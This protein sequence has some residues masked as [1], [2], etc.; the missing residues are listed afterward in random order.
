MWHILLLLPVVKSNSDNWAGVDL[1]F[2]LPGVAGPMNTGTILAGTDTTCVITATTAVNFVSSTTYTITVT[3]GKQRVVHASKGSWTNNNYGSK[4]SFTWESP[5]DGGDV[6]F[7]A[8]CATGNYNSGNMYSATQRIVSAYVPPAKCL[9]MQPNVGTFC[10][11]NGN[12]GL[13]NAAST[14]DCS[15]NPCAIAADASVCCKPAPP[16][17]CSTITNS[18]AFC[19]NNGN[20]GINPVASCVGIPCT[21][22]D[23]PTCCKPAANAAKCSSITDTMTF[24]ANKGNNGLVNNPGS[25]SCA[26]PVCTLSADGSTCCKPAPPAKCSSISNPTTFCPNNGNNGLIDDAENTFCDTSTCVASRDGVICCKPALNAAKCNTIT[27]PTSFCINHGNDG[28]VANPESIN[29]A[30]STCN[31]NPDAAKCC[32][33]GSDDNGSGNGS[34]SN[35][36]NTG[37]APSA[38]APAPAPAPA[39]TGVVSGGGVSISLDNTMSAV[40]RHDKKDNNLLN[41][42]VKHKGLGWFGIGVSS[43]GTMSSSGAGSDL[44]LCEEGNV[45]K[46]YWSVSKNLPTDG[47]VMNGATCEL[48]DGTSTMMFSRTYAKQNVKQRSIDKAGNTHFI[49]AWHATSKKLVYHT[50]RGSLS[51]KNL[52]DEL[53]ASEASGGTVVPESTT[54]GD[55]ALDIP[56]SS[57]IISHVVSMSV[58]WGLLLP[59]GVLIARYNR[60]SSWWFNVHRGIQYL[61]WAVQIVGVVMAF[62][63]KSDAHFLGPPVAVFHMILGIVVVVIGTLQPLNSCFR[64]HDNKKN[65]N[66]GTICNDRRVCWELVHKKSGYFAVLFGMLNC[67]LGGVVLQE[68]S[69]IV[70]IVVFCFCGLSC[71]GLVVYVVMH[72]TS[73]GDI[74]SNNNTKPSKYDTNPLQNETS[75][76]NSGG[77]DD[78]HRNLPLGWVEKMSSTHNQKYWYNQS[79]GETTWQR[80][81]L[82][83]SHDNGENS[84]DVA[85]ALEMPDM[86]TTL[87]AEDLPAG[88]LSKLSESTGKTYYISP[89]G[90]TQ[91]EAP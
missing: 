13:I 9:S 78:S 82:L 22:S 2:K 16:S 39:A 63:Y 10:A 90:E 73:D 87:P 32:L 67:F 83:A 61:G 75:S 77:G 25:V 68:K 19:A 20:N 1:S 58:S 43:D 70:S 44:I 31:I 21:S 85:V 3:G 30:T 24:C 8:N 62:I 57:T 45:V 51:L 55:D 60:K 27:N 76:G 56:M 26:T 33:P 72:K 64:P 53:E 69:P 79:T 6:T 91:W 47:I 4:T 7:S 29:C 41:F 74:I 65:P 34:G 48:V 81:T 42:E 23:A 18:A 86:S 59:L 5:N 12:N 46:R 52:K 40:V 88:W 66:R 50:K 54:G 28:L 14:T 11:N 49:H 38:P 17:K 84:N 71:F 80:P 15:G 36:G 89:D 35:G 37:A